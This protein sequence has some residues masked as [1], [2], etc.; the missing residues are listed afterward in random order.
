MLQRDTKIYLYICFILFRKTYSWQQVWLI[1]W[2][3]LAHIN[4]HSS[5]KVKSMTAH[6]VSDAGRNRYS[7][8]SYTL[9]LVPAVRVGSPEPV[10]EIWQAGIESREKEGESIFGW[11]KKK[12][13]CE[14]NEQNLSHPTGRSGAYTNRRIVF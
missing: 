5:L 9:E 11:R 12:F 2:Y 8:T 7:Y 14:A 6:S 13:N 10:M 4:S 3:L 1:P